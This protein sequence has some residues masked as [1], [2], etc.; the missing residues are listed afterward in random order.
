MVIAE[1]CVIF[2]QE[3]ERRRRSTELVAENL[4]SPLLCSE[5]ITGNL[6]GSYSAARPPL[7]NNRAVP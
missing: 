7:A 1:E 6:G 5:S 3:S 4:V 2:I